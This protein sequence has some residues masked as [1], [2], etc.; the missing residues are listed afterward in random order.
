MTTWNGRKWT[1]N[2]KM[3]DLEFKV[4]ATCAGDCECGGC[5]ACRCGKLVLIKRPEIEKALKPDPQRKKGDAF[6]WNLGSTFS[7]FDEMQTALQ[8]SVGWW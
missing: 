3:E 7:C 1:L 8:T 5:Q 2:N 6:I 4:R